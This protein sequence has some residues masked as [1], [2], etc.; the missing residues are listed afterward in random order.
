MGTQY[1]VRLLVLDYM[2]LRGAR[3]HGDVALD[4]IRFACLEARQI[5]ISAFVRPRQILATLSHASGIELHHRKLQ[6]TRGEDDFPNLPI[7]I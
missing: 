4:S 5:V 1:L 7:L 2:S 3:T 6:L